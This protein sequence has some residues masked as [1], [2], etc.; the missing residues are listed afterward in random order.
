MDITNEQESVYIGGLGEITGKLEGG[1]QANGYRFEIIL[2]G[3]RIHENYEYY[4][5]IIT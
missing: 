1:T 5:F 2:Q 3:L 4:Y